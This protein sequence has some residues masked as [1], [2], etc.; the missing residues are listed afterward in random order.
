MHFAYTTYKKYVAYATYIRYVAYDIHEV[1]CIC[2][3]H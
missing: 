2:Y 3:I 1:L